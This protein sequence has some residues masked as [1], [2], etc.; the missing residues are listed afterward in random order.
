[1]PICDGYQACI[2]ISQMFSSPGRRGDDT[3][4]KL[5]P[6][7]RRSKSLLAF[8]EEDRKPLIVALTSF[9]DSHIEQRALEAGF[10]MTL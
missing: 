6:K 3:N 8:D 2:Q 10:D 9:V 1:M 4:K 7:I 5:E